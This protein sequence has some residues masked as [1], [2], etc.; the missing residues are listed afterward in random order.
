MLWK[1]AHIWQIW[2]KSVF[3][4]KKS[5]P[6]KVEGGVWSRESQRSGREQ[7]GELQDYDLR[8]RSPRELGG[9]I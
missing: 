9:K 4:V 2:E 6:S 5:P 7:V 3:R 1:G 8:N